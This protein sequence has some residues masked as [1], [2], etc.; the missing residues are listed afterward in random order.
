MRVSS[1]GIVVYA[2]P[3]SGSFLKASGSGM[4]LPLPSLLRVPAIEASAAGQEQEVEVDQGGRIFLFTIVPI[5]GE[6]WVN[7][8]GRDITAI[9]EAERRLERRAEEL[10]RLVAKRT[11]RLIEIERF[12]AIGEIT[13][14]VAHDLRSPLQV[15]TS[16]L[17][18][19]KDRLAS[20]PP[21]C[22][23]AIDE[24]RLS[25][26]IHVME[27]SVKYMSRIISD[28]QGF[29]GHVKPRLSEV[30]I[31][32]L[33]DR[34]LK[35]M[36]VPA[37]IKIYVNIQGVP[38]STRTMVDEAM[39]MRVFTN[40]ATNA[41]EAMPKG[42]SLTVIASQKDDWLS[43]EFSDTGGGI[44]QE[45]MGKLFSP[46]FT[47]K[48][49]GTGL[50]LVICKRIVEAH[51]GRISVKSRAGEGTTFKVELPLAGGDQ[52]TGKGA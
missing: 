23:E 45:D 26:S 13:S 36:E 11:E 3:A 31:V 38:I 28:L 51:G 21:S 9:K 52:K 49:R 4:S 47:T 44:L 22:K 33:L 20:L 46:L 8:Y 17:Y 27:D 48:D 24:P 29:I 19:I 7:L 5:P 30:D 39:M 43:V 10:E 12:A 15:M 35:G 18:A 32:E 16:V 2:N 50:G 40:L 41:I 14:A 37:G 25:Q 34:T 42:G 6:G 1:D